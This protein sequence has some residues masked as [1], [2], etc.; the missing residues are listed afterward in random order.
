MPDTL[1]WGIISTARIAETAFIPA[2]RET[3]R[4]QIVAVASRD[5]ARAQAFAGKHDIAQVF[6]S[7]EAMLVSDEIDAVYNPLPNSL[8]AEWTIKAAGQGVHIFCEKPL[9]ATAS[10]AEQMV[11][12]CRDA[13]VLL[14][15]AFVF[16]Y[17]PMNQKLREVI[18]GGAIGDLVQMQASFTFPLERP[19]DNIRMSREAAGGS[20][21]DVGCYAIAYS[22]FIFGEEPLAVQAAVLMDPDYGVDTRASM[23][24]TYSGD[25]HAAL[26]EGFDAPGGQRAIVH[27]S[28]GYIEIAQPCH[29]REQD[30]FTIH[31]GEEEEIISV[32]AGVPPFTPAIEHFHDCILDGAQPKY[33]AA[34]AA[35]PAGSA[36]TLR[37]IEAVLE[38]GRTGQR[39]ELG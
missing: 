24:L 16:L 23:V 26:Q 38:S 37:I 19:T 32:N 31:R 2:L 20:L 5:Q 12:A 6:G 35:G 1:R 17:H 18:D 9:A 27:G 30:S 29:P 14:F 7:Y 25:R 3:T 10:E 33:T 11:S 36:G 28:K 13:D 4:G 15:E 34:N 22:R 8:H 21:M 39:I